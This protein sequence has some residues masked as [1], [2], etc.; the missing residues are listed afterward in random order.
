ML[1]ARFSRREGKWLDLTISNP[2]RAGFA[3][4]AETIL[5]ALAHPQ[6]MDYDP[7]PKGLRSA[8]EAVADYYREQTEGF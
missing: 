1:A 6:A 4:D 3:Y 8:R 7:Q 2:A 5:R